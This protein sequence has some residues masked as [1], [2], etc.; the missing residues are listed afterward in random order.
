MLTTISLNVEKTELVIF[1]HKKKKLECPIRIKLSRKR[2]YPSNSIK[3]LG[4][5]IDKNLNWND[6]IHDI[7][8]KLNRANALLFKI[9]NYVNFNTLKSIYFAIFDSHIDYAKLVWVQNLNFALRIVNLQ[10][11]AIRNINNQPRSSNS[12]LLFEKKQYS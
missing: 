8:T 9:R 10:K 4:V 12:S 3:Y 1:K 2:L 11:K 7:A 5:K 6:H